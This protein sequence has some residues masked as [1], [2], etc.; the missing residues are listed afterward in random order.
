MVK[1]APKNYVATKDKNEKIWEAIGTV[2][3][4]TLGFTWQ[5]LSYT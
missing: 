2:T 1:C 4:N 3:Q 5:N